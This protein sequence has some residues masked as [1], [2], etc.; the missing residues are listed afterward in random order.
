VEDRVVA[1][2]EDLQRVEGFG[3]GIGAGLFH[4]VSLAAAPD[5]RLILLARSSLRR[6]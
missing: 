3:A 4:D 1:A 5:S 6:A 2:G